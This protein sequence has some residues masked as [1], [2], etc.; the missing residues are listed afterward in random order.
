TKASSGRPAPRANRRTKSVMA[1]S[2]TRL[3]GAAPSEDAARADAADGSLAAA[4]RLE[5]GVA[6][7]G[8]AQGPSGSLAIQTRRRGL[9]T[10]GASGA[11]GSGFGGPWALAAPPL[12]RAR[13]PP[14]RGGP[15]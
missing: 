10:R 5:G 3:T 14:P 9:G 2:S 7:G 15:R 6:G 11:G 12:T 4:S 8:V 1:A 13:A